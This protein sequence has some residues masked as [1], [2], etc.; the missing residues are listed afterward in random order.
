MCR[1][2]SHCAVGESKE[3]PS[4]QETKASKQR[5]AQQSHVAAPKLPSKQ[6]KVRPSAGVETVAAAGVL[7]DGPATAGS[8]GTAA[9]APGAVA[10]ADAPA[11]QPAQELE[12][13]SDIAHEPSSL[14]S[15]QQSSDPATPTFERSVFE[16]AAAA[17]P[18]RKHPASG[19]LPAAAD[20]GA[21]VDAGSEV[22]VTPPAAAA[23]GSRARSSKRSRQTTTEVQVAASPVSAADTAAQSSADSSASRT[24]SVDNV[25]DAASTEGS[26]VQEA[27]AEP[28][29][30]QAAVAADTARRSAQVPNEAEAEHGAHP[31]GPALQAVHKL[32]SV[33]YRPAFYSSNHTCGHPWCAKRPYRRSDKPEAC[34]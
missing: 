14:P 24:T 27:A 2:L 13:V 15:R 12:N 33:A 11:A 6:A 17:K 29:G 7:V 32:G 9:A 20:A 34:P 1:P 26:H 16:A 28:P 22:P 21:G 10:P 23:A 8:T 18:A 19:A 3:K 4:K 31:E 30:L 25:Q 5:A